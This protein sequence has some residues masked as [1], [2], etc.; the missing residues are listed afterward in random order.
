M[1]SINSDLDDKDL[2]GQNDGEQS[3]AENTT[4]DDTKADAVLPENPMQLIK[5]KASTRYRERT[6]L[7]ETYVDIAKKM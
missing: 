3:G 4:T 6:A 7:W 2:I 1:R 5:D